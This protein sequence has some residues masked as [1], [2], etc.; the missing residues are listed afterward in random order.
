MSAS[1]PS[2]PLVYLSNGLVRACEIQL[3]HIGKNNGSPDLVCEN[4][5]VPLMNV[6]RVSMCHMLVCDLYFITIQ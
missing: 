5:S 2:G 3:S 6:V 4:V 1:G